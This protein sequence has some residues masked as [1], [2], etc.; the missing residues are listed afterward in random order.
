MFQGGPT[1]FN[2]IE[3]G[4]T[5]VV[6]QYEFDSVWQSWQDYENPLAINNSER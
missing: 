6:A 2:R 5:L 1:R 4:R 3:I